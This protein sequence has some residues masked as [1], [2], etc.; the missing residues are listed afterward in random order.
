MTSSSIYLFI[1]FAAFF[2]ALWNIIF[3]F[4]KKFLVGIAMKVFFQ[5]IIFFPIIFFVPSWGDNVV[6][7]YLFPNSSQSLLYPLKNMYNRGPN[8][9]YRLQ[10]VC[11]FFCTI[12]S[13][14]FFV[15]NSFIRHF[16]NSSY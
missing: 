12:L 9:Y 8:F 16:R 1:F 14:I 2:H 13:L 3:K 6:I 11:S 4:L 5:S 7:Y 10:E 15:D